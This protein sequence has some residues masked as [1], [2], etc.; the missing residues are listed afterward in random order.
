MY[1]SPTNSCSMINDYFLMR[2]TLTVMI[3]TSS[4]WGPS[5]S[6]GQHTSS[7]V[8]VPMELPRSPWTNT[9]LAISISYRRLRQNRA[10]NPLSYRSVTAVAEDG[11]TLNS[12]CHLI[13]PSRVRN[14][15]VVSRVEAGLFLRY[16]SIDFVALPFSE[17]GGRAVC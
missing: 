12:L 1:H 8:H 9:R 16:N 10:L 11:G 3:R 6:F 7:L 17:G 14:I 5:I 15:D 2:S 4:R 13:Y